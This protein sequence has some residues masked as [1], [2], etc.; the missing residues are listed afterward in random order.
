[1]Q[2]SHSTICIFALL[3]S[4]TGS[5]ICTAQVSSSAQPPSGNTNRSNRA[6]MRTPKPGVCPLPILEAL[7]KYTDTA[8]YTRTDVPHGKV[9]QTTYTNTGGEAKR[10][11]VYLP[12]NYEKSGKSYPVLYLNHG[13]GDDDSKWTSTDPR[14][15]GNAQFILDNLIAAG[16]AR[17]MIVVMPNTRRIAAAKPPAFGQNDACAD[18]FLKCIIPHVEKNYRAT[19]SRE[20][21]A[22]AGLSMG[23]FVV[24]NTGFPHLETFSELYVYSSGYIS[25]DDRKALEENYAKLLNDPDTNNR[26]RV[27]L[28]FAAGETDIALYNCLKTMA[29]FNKAGIRNFWVLSDG[30]HDWVNWRRY[31]WQTAQVMFPEIGVASAI[32]VQSL[33]GQWKAEFDTQI[34]MQKYVF[35]LKVEGGKITGNT[36]AEIDGQKYEGEIKEGKFSGEEV[37]FVENLNFQENALVITYTGKL[38]GNEMKLT[39]KVGDFATEELTAKR[40]E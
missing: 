9:E 26:F 18:E 29:V 2:T 34:G 6:M 17:P 31:L 21:R 38:R 39:R 1:M 15:G 32:Q 33:A 5:S 22:L 10:M 12:P 28:Y 23:G 7:P 16:K 40:V 37:T 35:T 25:D 13:G 27:P 19:P 3:V 30:G 8:F 4:L 24:L 20:N 11:H 36:R 14:N